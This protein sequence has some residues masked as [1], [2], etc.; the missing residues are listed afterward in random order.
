MKFNTIALCVLLMASTGCSDTT[1]SISAASAGTTAPL[2][3]GTRMELTGRAFAPPA[4]RHFCARQARLCSTSGSQK[5]VELSDSR[6]AELRKVNNSVNR[7]IIERSDVATSGR[8]DDWRVPAKYGDCE[9]YAILKKAELIK[10]GWPASALLLTV[11]RSGGEG[12][13]VLT[14]RTSRG[15]LILDN[16]TSSVK[17]WSHTPYR[18]FARQSQENGKAWERIGSA[19]PII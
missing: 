9:D 19:I 6:L 4:F 10:L 8:A 14:A 3:G 16:R 13:T 15:D 5:L 11:A 7:R 18:Y 2:S 17:D 1:G 12:H